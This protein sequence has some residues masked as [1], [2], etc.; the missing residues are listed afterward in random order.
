VRERPRPSLPGK[1]FL[2][3]RARISARHS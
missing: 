3:R 2:G 1:S